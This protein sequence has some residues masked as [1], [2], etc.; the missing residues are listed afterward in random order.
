MALAN[1]EMFI[2]VVYR[3]AKPDW[4]GLDKKI[5]MSSNTSTSQTIPVYKLVYLNNA[6]LLAVEPMKEVHGLLPIVIGAL[7]LTATQRHSQMSVAE[8]LFPP[9]AY[10]DK[11][12]SARIAFLRRVLNERAIY[13][14]NAIKNPEAFND[15]S[16]SAKIPLELHRAEDGS[17][18]IRRAYLPVPFDSSGGAAL[19]GMLG[20]GDLLAERAIGNSA[21][22]RGGRTPGNKLQF[23][24]QREATMAEGR[25]QVFAIILQQTLMSPFKRILR[26]NLGNTAGSLR[27]YD[28]NSGQ[29]RAVTPQEFADSEFDFGIS[30]GLLPSHKRVNPDALSGLITAITQI[31]QLQAEFDLRVLFEMFGRA[32]GFEDIGRV[33]RPQQQ[34]Q[35]QQAPPADQAAQQEPPPEAQAALPAA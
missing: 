9:Q 26:S 25:F 17:T 31:P 33:P 16:G 12:T 19:L 21:Q 34:A 15:T 6:V 35:P 28:K 20:E 10:E 30:D 13:D 2:T 24:A 4:L 1:K 23:E 22:M 11:L 14:K 7:T 5:Y 29:K 32:S 3:R 18:D 27:Y 8:L